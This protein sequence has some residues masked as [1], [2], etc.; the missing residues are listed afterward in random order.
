[1]GALYIENGVTDIDYKIC[2]GADKGGFSNLNP[3]KP[4]FIF[5]PKSVENIGWGL[6]STARPTY[7]I[8]AGHWSNIIKDEGWNQSPTENNVYI[9]ED[10]YLYSLA[11]KIINR[12]VRKE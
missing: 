4:Y 5:I 11:D 6:V 10:A 2:Y 9:M 1:M 8:C 3:N 7:I 12:Y